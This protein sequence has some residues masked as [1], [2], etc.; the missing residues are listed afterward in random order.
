MR[1]AVACLRVINDG[2][3]ATSV[4]LGRQDDH[5]SNV[6]IEVIAVRDLIT[7]IIINHHAQEFILCY[8]SKT[9]VIL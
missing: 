8:I 2:I 7:V 3:T 5:H 9:I 4:L 1:S 6:I